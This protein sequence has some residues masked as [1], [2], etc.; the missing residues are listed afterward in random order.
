[1]L[2]DCGEGTQRQMMR[3]QSGFG[4]S[5]ILF[6]HMHADHL[7]GVVGLV[8]TMGLQ[9]REDPIDLYGPPGSGSTLRRAV[10]LG[11]E[12]VSFPVEIHEVEPGQALTF[13]EYD[14]RT[15]PVEHATPSIGWA[16]IE[17]P[18]LGRFDVERARALGIEEGPLF[19]RLHRGESVTVGDR[20][21]HAEE[22]VG[23][24]RPGRKVVISGDTRP[25]TATVQIAH[26]A[27]V[28][29]HEATFCTDEQDRALQTRHSTAAEAAEVARAAEVDRLVLTHV[30]ARYSDQPGALEDEARAVFPQ[31][32]VAWDGLSLEV[33]F[34]DDAEDSGGSSEVDRAATAQASTRP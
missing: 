4:V 26:G 31:T 24:S 17:H 8:R 33:G 5:R 28:L 25:C 1:M 18:R 27:D 3:Y 12:R 29:V 20:T 22:V 9:G 21:V 16:L 14:L 2:V 7:L 32:T 11:I 10:H 19:G 13:D 23:P 6:T 30:S 34:K 15:F